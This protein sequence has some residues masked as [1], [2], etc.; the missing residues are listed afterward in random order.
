[1]R[2]S[3]LGSPSWE[4]GLWRGWPTVPVCQGPRGFPG[5]GTFLT[6]TGRCLASQDEL[7]ALLHLYKRDPYA[8]LLL[9]NLQA[10]PTCPAHSLWAQSSA[11]I[12]RV[13][14]QNRP[15]VISDGSWLLLILFQPLTWY[16]GEN[17]DYAICNCQVG[18]TKLDQRWLL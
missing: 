7:V 1:M 14:W 11:I 16:I 18:K 13:W 12:C 5:H 10:W 2:T 15:K 17:T 8:W 6:K 9:N 3:S 4:E